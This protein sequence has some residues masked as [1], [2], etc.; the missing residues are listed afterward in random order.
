MSKSFKN[1]GQLRGYQAEGVSWMLSNHI[2]NQGS[3]LADEMG[4]GYV[5]T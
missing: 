3:I 1:G 4:L 5:L 2:N